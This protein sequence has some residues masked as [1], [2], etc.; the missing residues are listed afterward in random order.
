MT[1]SRDDENGIPRRRSGD[2]GVIG[3]INAALD[4]YRFVLW[5]IVPILTLYGFRVVGPGDAIATVNLAVKETQANVQHIEVDSLPAI[6]R[7]I[8][9]VQD[10]TAALARLQCFSKLVTEDERDLA[11]LNCGAMFAG[12]YRLKRQGR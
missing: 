7:D 6:H 3:Q 10:E 5:L 12:A 8:G 4:R 9:A 1:P 2:S 11:G